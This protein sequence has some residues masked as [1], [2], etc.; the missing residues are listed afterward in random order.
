LICIKRPFGPSGYR[1]A[2][3]AKPRDNTQAQTSL[4]AEIPEALLLIVRLSTHAAE[5]SPALSAA[6]ARLRC[7]RPH[8]GAFKARIDLPSHDAMRELVHACG[9]E[10]AM[11]ILYAEV[12]PAA[13]GIQPYHRL[14]DRTDDHAELIDGWKKGLCAL[15]LLVPGELIRLH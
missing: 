8:D 2:L 3:C 4:K 10:G 11:A 12:A 15:P 6:F 7:V 9:A 13:S 1:V 5:P 14:W